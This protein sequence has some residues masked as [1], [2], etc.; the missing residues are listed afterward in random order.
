MVFPQVFERQEYEFK[1]PFL[2]VK[3]KI[4]RREGTM[5]VV[6]TRVKP[7]RVMDKVPQSKN[8]G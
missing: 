8:W 3:G 4:S 6:V 7:F 2:M 5:N 1:L